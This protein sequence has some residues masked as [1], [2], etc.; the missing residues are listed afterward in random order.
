VYGNQCLHVIDTPITWREKK[1][2]QWLFPPTYIAYCRK[3]RILLHR[4]LLNCHLRQVLHI[5]SLFIL[6][7]PLNFPLILIIFLNCIT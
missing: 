5:L 4:M 2:Q 6:L 1:S 7:H 3:Y